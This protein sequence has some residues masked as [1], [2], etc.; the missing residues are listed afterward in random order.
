MRLLKIKVKRVRESGATHYTYPQPHYDML[1]IVFGPIY[2][3]G[4]DKNL[5]S[6]W[7][8][9]SQDSGDEYIIVGVKNINVEKALI[10]D[11]IQEI[12]KQECLDYGSLWTGGSVPVIT[13]M[14]KVVQ[15]LAKVA[16]N[17]SLTIEEKNSIDPKSSE[18]G[19]NNTPTFEEDLNKYIGANPD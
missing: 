16:R 14:D 6:I 5:P 8:R 1:N 7:A 9:A 11:D 3:G 2:E 15:I 18:P 10:N 17:E 19:I 4:M 12:T 13:N